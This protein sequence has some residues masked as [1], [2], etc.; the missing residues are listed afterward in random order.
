ML[1]IWDWLLRTHY[2]PR[3]R[4]E[5]QFGIGDE[6]V[7]P[8]PHLVAAMLEPFAYAWRVVRKRPAPTAGESPLP[9]GQA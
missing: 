3:E 1:A 4:E 5:L 7:Q 6:A 9:D 2:Q 8:H